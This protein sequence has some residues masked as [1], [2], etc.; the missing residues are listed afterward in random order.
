MENF[1]LPCASSIAD[2]VE[3]LVSSPPVIVVVLLGSHCRIGEFSDKND[4]PFM[5][6]E[7]QFWIEAHVPIYLPPEIVIFPFLIINNGGLF[8]PV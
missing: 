6:R 5:F 3:P 7:A 2:I 4:P 1:F 8:S